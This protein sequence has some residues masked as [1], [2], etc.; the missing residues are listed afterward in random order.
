MGQV[1]LGGTHESV[2]DEGQP[3]HVTGRCHWLGCV[4]DYAH[5]H[6][7]SCHWEAHVNSV[8]DEGFFPRMYVCALAQLSLPGS[9]E[10]EAHLQFHAHEQCRSRKA[11]SDACAYFVT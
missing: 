7:R 6:R 8:A 9:T 3:L 4:Q 2:P 1:S 5:A 11:F 10:L